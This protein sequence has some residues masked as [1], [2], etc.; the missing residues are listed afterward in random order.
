MAEKK[1]KKKKGKDY[2]I[3]PE[4][5]TKVRDQMEE[6]ELDE[7]L[8]RMGRIRLAR[9]LKR[10]AKSGKLKRGKNRMAKKAMTATRA[11]GLGIRG[12]WRQT[13]Q[14]LAGGK[15]ISSL[16]HAQKS[17][18]EKLA[19]KKVAQRKALSKKIKRSKLMNSVI[20]DAFGV[21][22]EGKRYHNLLD[23]NNKPVLDKRFKMFKKPANLGSDV[24]EAFELFYDLENKDLVEAAVYTLEKYYEADSLADVRTVADNFG[25][26]VDDLSR[27]VSRAKYFK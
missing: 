21:M 27:A 20:D 25:L 1:E 26:D 12:S 13:K 7:A 9:S 18:V 19:S 14:K 17:R 8:T 5:E 22:L 3:N 4:L 16:S 6:T 24:N 2:E 15:S 10:S 23:K 11:T